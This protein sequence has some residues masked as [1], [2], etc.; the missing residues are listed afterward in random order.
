MSVS[1]SAD[2][3][4]RLHV[5]RASFE[6]NGYVVV[7]GL[8]SPSDMES[9]ERWTD[10]VT[11]MPEMPGKQMVYYEDDLRRPGHRLLSRIENFCPFHTHFND[12][13]TAGPVVDLVS[14][15]MGDPVVLFKEKINFKMPGADGFKAHQDVQAGWD[16]Y[17]PLHVTM[18]LSIDE[19]T[20]ENGCLSILPGAH[21]TGLLGTHWAP[22]EGHDDDER[23]LL[24]PTQPGDVIFF[25]SYVPHRSAPN[26][27]QAARRV[28]YV[29]YNLAN[30]GDHRVQ[31]YIDKRTSYPP[32]NERDPNREYTYRV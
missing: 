21:R 25:D 18:L 32:D 22:L 2:H 3:I 31:Y 7:P 29:S 23:Y 15:L 17:A 30:E 20:P 14:S 8:F 1:V 6:A 10:E 16:N 24:C 28:L 11:S 12:F 4:S 26:I 9:I 19:A 27:T 13:L 5:D